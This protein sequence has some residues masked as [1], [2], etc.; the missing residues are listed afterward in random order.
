MA[1]PAINHVEYDLGKGK[2]QRVIPDFLSSEKLM[3]SSNV[4]VSSPQRW[5]TI[6][7]VELLPNVWSQYEMGGVTTEWVGSLPNGWSHYQIDGVVTKWVES[8]LNGWRLPNGWN[9]Y[10][11]GGVTT[12]GCC[13]WMGGVTTELVKSLPKGWS[14][15][16]RGGITTG[17][18]QYWSHISCTSSYPFSSF[19]LSFSSYSPQG[20]WTLDRC[21]V[22]TAVE[23]HVPVRTSSPPSLVFSLYISSCLF[24]IK[25]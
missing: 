9:C 25:C 13:Y 3:K 4:H 1:A 7:W 11:M 21:P 6:A 12:N 23:W 14:H 16:Q 10:K 18:C 8:L 2:P 15:Y 24:L 5:L 22:I 17:V 20:K 19:S